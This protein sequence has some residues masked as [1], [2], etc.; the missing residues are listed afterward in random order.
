MITMRIK[1]KVKKSNKNE[2][3]KSDIEGFDIIARINVVREK[4]KANFELIKL[5][6]EYYSISQNQVKIILGKTNTTKIIEI[7]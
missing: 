4:N 1:V 6:S 2:I 5:I 3:I 7:L